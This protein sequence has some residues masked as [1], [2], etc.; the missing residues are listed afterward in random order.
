V[1]Y[2]SGS[3]LD[4]GSELA[5]LDPTVEKKLL[6]VLAIAF[7]SEERVPSIDISEIVCVLL[8]RLAASLTLTLTISN[9]YM[10]PLSL[11]ACFSHLF[12]T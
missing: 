7:V 11:C 8:L 12:G 9:Y 2:D 6:N 3:V 4:R 5:I 10:S 1:Q